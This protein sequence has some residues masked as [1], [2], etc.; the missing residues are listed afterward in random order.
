MASRKNIFNEKNVHIAFE[1][2]LVLKGMFAL[3][4]IA[5]SI[6]TYFVTQQFVLRLVQAVTR[7]ELT[8]DP[9]DYLANYMLHA[10]QNLSVSS[11]HFA[12]FYLLSHG[13]IKIGL[14]I[15]LWREKIAFYQIAIVVFG[16]FIAYQVYRYSFT[17]SLLLLLLLITALDGVVILLTWIEYRHLR[18][19]RK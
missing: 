5:V 6:F 9:R 18:H 11:Q 14:I 17:H 8:E 2:S 7:T 16:L 13:I 12:A 1:F 15:G 10:A 4:E 3:V 19:A